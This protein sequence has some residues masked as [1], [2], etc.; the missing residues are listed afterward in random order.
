MFLTVLHLTHKC[1]HMSS[2]ST[3]DTMTHVNASLNVSNT[4]FKLYPALDVIDDWS[5]VTNPVSRR[6]L[7]NR[8]NQRAYRLRKRTALPL[9]ARVPESTVTGTSPPRCMCLTRVFFIQDTH[10]Q[11]L[12]S[13]LFLDYKSSFEG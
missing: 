8:L 12:T 2:S 5:G 13:Y 11:M 3:P 10:Q 9:S 1:N 4:F 7:Q 6:R